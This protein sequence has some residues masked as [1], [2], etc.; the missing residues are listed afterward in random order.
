MGGDQE[1]ISPFFFE[2]EANALT[3]LLERCILGIESWRDP[4]DEV[5][6]NLSPKA[7]MEIEREMEE[8]SPKVDLM[9]AANCPDCNREFE[10]PFDLQEFFFGELRNSRDLLYREVHYLAYHYHWSE[11]EIMEMPKEKRHGY[12]DVLADEI[13][14]LNNAI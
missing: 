3:M 12:I 11:R 10:L 9:M 6:R 13:E 2:N 14:R 8:V 7:R 5:I 1:A 4:L